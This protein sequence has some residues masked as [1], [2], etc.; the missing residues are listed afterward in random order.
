MKATL[1]RIA[2]VCAQ[3]AIAL[4]LVLF[5]GNMLHDEATKAAPDRWV[6]GVAFVM[7]LVGVLSAPFAGSVVMIGIKRGIAAGQLGRRAYDDKGLVVVTSDI[8]LPPPEKK[9]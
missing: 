6:E 1:L 7:L 9:S 4:A 2:V 3:L 5:F 8:E